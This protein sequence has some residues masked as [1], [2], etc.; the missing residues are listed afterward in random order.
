[1]ALRFAGTLVKT[2][3]YGPDR[4]PQPRKLAERS[5]EGARRGGPSGLRAEPLAKR[6]CISRGS[7]YWHFTDVA[8]F[9]RAVLERWELASVDRPLARSTRPGG[10]ASPDADL[11]R[12]IE[13][14]FT[15]PTAL[16]RAVHAWAAVY[17]PA[18]V[19]VAGVNRRRT[20]LLADMF[21]RAGVPAREAEGRAGILYW[22]YLGYMTSSDGP[23]SA[24]W[25]GEIQVIFAFL[26]N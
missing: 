11:P 7:F 13:I 17:P 4:N 15:S 19:A 22:A 1:M 18:A 23:A 3:V 25:I 12:L 9:H 20:A 2:P 16:K 21:A 26:P 8:E 24:G 5:A 10:D 6:L 14:A